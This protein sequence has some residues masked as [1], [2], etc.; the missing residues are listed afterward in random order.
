MGEPYT[1]RHARLLTFSAFILQIHADAYK[2]KTEHFHVAILLNS[3]NNK[4]AIDI[5]E[6]CAP[7][8]TIKSAQQI[9]SRI[10]LSIEKCKKPVYD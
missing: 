8:D 7:I 5:I 2:K 1:T 10:I 6:K 9:A 4:M 3:T